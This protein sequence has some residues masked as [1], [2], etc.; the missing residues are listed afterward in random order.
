VVVLEDKVL[1]RQI[2]HFC[3]VSHAHHMPSRSGVREVG[4]NVEVDLPAHHSRVLPGRNRPVVILEYDPSVEVDPVSDIASR[5][6]V[7]SR[8]RI[9]IY[10]EQTPRLNDGSAPQDVALPRSVK[11]LE[12]PDRQAAVGVLEKNVRR[13]VGVEIVCGRDVPTRAR[14]AQISLV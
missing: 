6:Y 13:P 9:L 1:T 4:L 2:E 10:I 12:L 5:N 11:A 8:S 7:P 3:E 14:V